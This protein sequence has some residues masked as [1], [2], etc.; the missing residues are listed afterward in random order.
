MAAASNT[1]K[2][3]WGGWLG[4]LRRRTVGPFTFGLIV[5]GVP[6]AIAFSGCRDIVSPE[7]LRFI[8]NLTPL[9]IIVTGI[10]AVLGAIHKWKELAWRALVSGF[11]ACLPF[12]LVTS[13]VLMRRLGY[14]A[15]SARNLLPLTALLLAWAVVTGILGWVIALLFELLFHRKKSAF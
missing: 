3:G 4:I 13:V 10:C 12:P 15:F 5:G 11:S 1:R 2:S 8:L 6:L 9:I 14:D 7:F